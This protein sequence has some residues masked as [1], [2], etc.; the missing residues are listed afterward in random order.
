[1]IFPAAID[2]QIVPGIA[3]PLKAKVLEQGGAAQGD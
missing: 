3:L 2:H 1:M